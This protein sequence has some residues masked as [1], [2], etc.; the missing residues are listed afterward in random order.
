VVVVVFSPQGCESMLRGVGFLDG[1]GR[2]S[3]TA[4][5]RWEDGASVR[6]GDGLRFVIA[7]IGPT[8]RDHLRDKFGFEPDV[9]AK[10]P[11]PEGLGKGVREFLVEK[12]LV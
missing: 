11:S 3:E 7:T 4:R 12:G 6:E 1:E 2:V 8:T 10:K 5:R 9:C